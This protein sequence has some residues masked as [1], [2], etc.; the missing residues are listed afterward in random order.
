[1]KFVP[2]FFLIFHICQSYN[3]LRL[4]SSVNLSSQLVLRL[5][6]T[7]MLSL[8]GCLNSPAP[9]L[10][11]KTWRWCSMIMTCWPETRRSARPWLTWKTASSP[12]MEP[13]VVCP[14]LTVCEC[15]RNN[16]IRTTL[17][18]NLDMIKITQ[19]HHV[20]KKKL[21]FKPRKM[22]VAFI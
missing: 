22:K 19:T 2:L 9:S 8:S 18:Q 14:S 7:V 3:I 1:M 21:K 6:L 5:L 12:N 13:C 15:D 20:K 11:R 10:W 4:C 16:A 17:L